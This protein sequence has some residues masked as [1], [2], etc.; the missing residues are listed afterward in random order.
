MIAERD[1]LKVFL[2]PAHSPDLNPVEGVW[3]HVERSLANLAVKALD[4]FENIVRNRPKRLQ[5]RPVVLNG[6][7]ASTGLALEIPTTP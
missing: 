5:C 3:G 7:I 6:F 2:L 4:R 1:W